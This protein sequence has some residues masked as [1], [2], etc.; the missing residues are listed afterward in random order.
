MKTNALPSV[1]SLVGKYIN[2]YGW[3]DVYP[4]GKVIGTKGK[5]TLI[6]KPIESVDITPPGTLK[7]HIGGFS[8]HCSNGHAQ[9]WE[10]NEIDETFEI[11]LS[12][13]L[14]K[15]CKVADAPFRFHDYNF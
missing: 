1:E 3:S 6:M 8:A 15:S 4:V 10:Y 13:G 11:R 12:K 5:T 9:V 2:R 14:M 7:F